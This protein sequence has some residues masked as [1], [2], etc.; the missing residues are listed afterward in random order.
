MVRLLRI[1]AGIH[2]VAEQQE[3]PTEADFSKLQSELAQLRADHP[4]Q[5][6]IR[7][8]QAV[9]AGYLKRP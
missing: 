3:K 7:I 6:H 9:I 2:A 5:V 8:L 1:E 4:D